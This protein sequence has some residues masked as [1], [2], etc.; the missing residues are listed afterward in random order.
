MRFNKKK[1]LLSIIL[2]AIVLVLWV[3]AKSVNSQFTEGYLVQEEDFP[4]LS[5]EEI[6][7]VN[8]QRLYL[9]ADTN[10]AEIKA[11]NSLL[12][13]FFSSINNRDYESAF[14]YF[15]REYIEWF[16][17]SFESFAAQ[18]NYGEE[19]SFLI[20][21]FD[22]LN[23]RIITKIEIYQ[24][25]QDNFIM[26]SRLPK[27]TQYFTVFEDGTIADKAIIETYELNRKYQ[28]NTIE[29]MV[30]RVHFLYDGIIFDV[31]VT[32]NGNERILIDTIN[33]YSDGFMADLRV[34]NDK[35]F[36]YDIAA[37]E[38]QGFMLFFPHSKKID[39][40]E[41]NFKGIGNMIIES[42]LEN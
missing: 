36:N 8:K 40:L 23:D 28:N 42:D 41:I 10:S 3:R 7:E 37:Y 16:N 35:F 17:L 13:N 12:L 4:Q 2:L 33:G 38:N 27:V 34:I 14:K 20:K 21:T 6:N 30:R 15:S 22:I 1:I 9:E 19:V 24:I 5:Q 29:S 31:L 32:N 26:R 11:V 18:Y 25:D 39:Y